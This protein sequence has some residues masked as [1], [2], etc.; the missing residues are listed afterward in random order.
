MNRKM[1]ALAPTLVDEIR[2]F[3][4]SVYQGNIQLGAMFDPRCSRAFGLQLRRKQTEFAEDATFLAG[5]YWL[6]FQCRGPF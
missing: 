6:E 5:G 4:G 2:L 3:A 1:G